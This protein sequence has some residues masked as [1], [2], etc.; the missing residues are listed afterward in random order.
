MG[1]IMHP[2]FYIIIIDIVILVIGFLIALTIDR[3]NKNIDDTVKY[4][5]NMTEDLVA[6]S[7]SFEEMNILLDE[8]R[9]RLQEMLDKIEKRRNRNV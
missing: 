4:I 5:H 2:I 6:I 7:K 1:K 3:A 9:A 8:K